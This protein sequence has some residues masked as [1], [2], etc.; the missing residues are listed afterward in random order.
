L[1]EGDVIVAF[2]GEPVSNI[3]ELHKML[4]AEQIGVE[5]KIVIVRHTEKLELSIFPAESRSPD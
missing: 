2:N 3:H 1:R 4:M 5:T